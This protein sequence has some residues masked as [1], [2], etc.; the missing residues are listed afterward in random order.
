MDSIEKHHAYLHTSGELANRERE[1][2][3]HELE[4]HLR[5]FLLASLLTRLGSGPYNAA[6][7]QIFARQLDPAR[8][9][10]QLVEQMQHPAHV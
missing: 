9:A 8:A 4:Q 3:E 2:L 1:R 6:L 7:E 10:R 5:E